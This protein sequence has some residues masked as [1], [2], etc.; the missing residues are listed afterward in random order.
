[1]CRTS[2]EQPAS[3]KKSDDAALDR[4]VDESETGEDDEGTP[5]AEASDGSDASEVDDL[6]SSD[7]EK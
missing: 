6:L 4:K 2:K 7:D 1:M 5:Q 3:K